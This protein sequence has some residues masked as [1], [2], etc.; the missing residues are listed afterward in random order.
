MG[1]ALVHVVCTIA[2]V[3]L[4]V[5]GSILYPPLAI[6]TLAVI[7]LGVWI[8]RLDDWWQRSYAM[9]LI[10]MIA[11]TANIEAIAVAG[12]YAKIATLGLWVAVTVASTAGSIP[13]IRGNW[14]KF[15]LTVLWATFGVA[16]LSLL[17]TK[18]IADTAL[19]V[20]I[21]GAFV[22]VVHRTTTRRWQSD[23]RIQNDLSIAF[24]ILLAAAAVSLLMS[25]AGIGDSV[26]EMTGRYQGLFNNP[27]L[28]AM[29]SAL[30][31][32]L[33][34]SWGVRMRHP[35]W[36]VLCII[37]LSMVVLSGARTS[38]LALVIALVIALL[39]TRGVV[40]VAVSMG[41][42]VATLVLLLVRPDF[43][44]GP[45]ER[46]FNSAG[47]STLSG[48]TDAWAE[49]VALLFTDGLGVG[50][51]A[52]QNSLAHYGALGIGSG[53]DSV[54]NAYL[55]VVY[56][57][58]WLGVL[59]ALAMMVLFFGL[60]FAVPRQGVWSSAVVV[61]LTGA[62]I[63]FAESPVFGVGQIYPY[64]FWLT[65]FAACCFTR[66]LRDSQAEGPDRLRAI[67]AGPIRHQDSGHSRGTVRN[68][69]PDSR[70]GAGARSGPQSP[71]P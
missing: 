45:L 59:I 28:L 13:R 70:R 21:Y 34:V 15:G 1:R 5:G 3:A 69:P 61:V 18:Y 10:S 66:P 68:T 26:S 32:A 11:G 41:T 31:V 64:V 39:R 55:Q 49:V 2:V 7:A 19:Q 56:E 37:P 60:V 20:C 33:G 51:A 36:I 46:F 54:H 52:T 35:S 4:A 25:L 48:R 30:C 16:C 29:T 63:H 38:L 58:G 42:V 17:W 9:M 47:D 6:I 65:V 24:W 71:A 14:H 43:T 62:L 67:A 23:E 50:W 53:L 8:L 12:G 22:F 44:T 57:L 27:N 40:T